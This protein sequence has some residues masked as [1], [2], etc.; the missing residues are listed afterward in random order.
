MK[1]LRFSGFTLVELII[2]VSLFF[3]TTTAGIVSFSRFS[4]SQVLDTSVSE[5]ITYLSGTRSNAVSQQ[6]QGPC[7]AQLQRYSVRFSTQDTYELWVYCNNTSYL[8]KSER[9]PNGV[10]FTGGTSSEVSFDASTGTSSG[11]SIRMTGS[12][13]TQVI[14]VD[15]GGNIARQ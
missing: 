3:V 9:L 4:T 7:T 11:G 1:K 6:M 12:G 15:T 13:S 8:L 10:T 2:V 14:Q 5:M